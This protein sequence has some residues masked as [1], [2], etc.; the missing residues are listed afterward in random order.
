MAMEKIL[1]SYLGF[2]EGTGKARS[3][4]SSYQG[5]ILVFQEFL[6]KKKIPFLKV[7]KRDFESY[8]NYLLDRGLK[9]NTRRRKLITARSLYRYAYS[10]KK[11]E[12]SPAKFIR[13]PQAIEKLPW[14]P[15]PKD[16]RRFYGAFSQ[17]TPLGCRNVL[18]VKILGEMGIMI[19]ELCSLRWTHWDGS[20][21]KIPGKRERYLRAS[22]SLQRI[23]KLWRTHHSG[24]F[25]FPGY[26]RHGLISLRMTPRG[27]ELLFSRVAGRLGYPEMKPKTLRHFAIV[28]W[29]KKK[30]SEKEIQRRIGVRE[31]YSLAEY[32]EYLKKLKNEEKYCKK[33][34]T[35]KK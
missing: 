12:I 6:K 2:L 10:R 11:I 4:I 21:L 8:H 23:L 19:S 31:E 27:V 32:R 17:K 14:L 25:L 3:T 20:G 30:V 9:T 24:N 26:N 28:Q 18:V 1:K 13:P 29:L 15:R 34:N 22:V 35:S 5:D 33:R 16:Y 7:M